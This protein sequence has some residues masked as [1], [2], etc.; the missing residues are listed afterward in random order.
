VIPPCDFTRKEVLQLQKLI[1]ERVNEIRKSK[2]KR[3]LTYNKGLSRVARYRLYHMYQDDD[4]S[5]IGPNGWSFLHTM[6]RFGYALPKRGAE[7]LLGTTHKPSQ[8][9][10]TIAHEMVKAWMSSPPHRRSLLN[11]AYEITGVGVFMYQRKGHNTT[12]SSQLFAEKITRFK[13]KYS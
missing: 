9:L 8:G 3:P 6:N 10:Q 7:N 5:H 2:G 13:P 4:F 11:S 12:T 1:F